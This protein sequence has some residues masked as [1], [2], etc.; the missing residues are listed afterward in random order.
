MLPNIY[1][2]EESMRLEGGSFS[3]EDIQNCDT[4]ADL[5]QELV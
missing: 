2:K 4:I 1:K 5:I 3:Q